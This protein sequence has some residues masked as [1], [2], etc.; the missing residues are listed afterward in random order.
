MQR[1]ILLLF[2]TCFLL[3]GIYTGSHASLSH[4][5]LFV[6]LGEDNPGK[7][8]QL[9]VL[10]NGEIIDPNTQYPL[11]SQDPRDLELTTDFQYILV[12][13]GY[14]MNCFRVLNDGNL[15]SAS[16]ISVDLPQNFTITPNNDLVVV[17]GYTAT[18]I[19]SLTTTGDLINE[20][21]STSFSRPKT[22]PFGRGILGRTAGFTFS[23][24]TIDY[25][26]RTL[27]ITTTYPTGHGGSIGFTYTHDGNLG[28]VYGNS[29]DPADS[30]KDLWVLNIDS[31]FN[32]TTTSQ[33]FDIPGGNG[34]DEPMISWDN[35]Y[36]WA[37]AGY[38]GIDLLIID[39][40]ETVTDTGRRYYWQGIRFIRKTPD[41]RLMMVGYE[42]ATTGG[43][44]FTSAWINSDGSLT[45]TGYTFPFDQTYP[46]MGTIIDAEVVP[47]YVTAVPEKLWE[48]L[49]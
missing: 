45:W 2:L 27:H 15:L 13:S 21:P 5:N 37:S 25:A 44:C 24:F 11:V 47:V 31:A 32:V 29:V 33:I 35:R 40:T 28:F 12:A 30:G 16:T 23:A 3:I 18:S 48:I 43:G 8:Y 39:T 46:S 19:F 4:Y 1:L 9:K 38:G 20:I 7:L 17:S 26:M 22:E 34:I 10:P 42:D 14:G 36:I 6:I 49:Q 41:E